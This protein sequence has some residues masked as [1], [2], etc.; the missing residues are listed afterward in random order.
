MKITVGILTVS[1]RSARGLRT[2]ASGPALKTL[3]EQKGWRVATCA[4][5]PDEPRDIQRVLLEWC[6]QKRLSLVLTTGGTGISPR[7]V[8]PE[9][10]RSLLDKELPGICE[11]MRREGAKQT[12]TAVLSR[13]VAGVRTRSLVINLPG[14]P[15]G[16]GESLKSIWE[17][18]PH[19]IAITRGEDHEAAGIK[20]RT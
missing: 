2:D 15:Q 20:K 6:D 13:A 12:P 19:A 8:T 11:L 17:I 7:D 10:T 9:A 5:V 3:I 18:I 14:N 4:L 16:A 1:D